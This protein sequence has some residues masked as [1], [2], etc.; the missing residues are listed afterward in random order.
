M[1]IARFYCK[2]AKT[3]FSLLPD[4]LSSRYRGEL[5]A[6]ETVCVAAER[7]KDVMSIANEHRAQN[8]EP[9]TTQ[10]AA[11]RWVLRRCVL[12]AIGMHA[13]RG[14]AVDLVQGLRTASELRERMSTEHAL[15]SLRAIVALNLAS[16]PPPLGFGPWPNADRRRR[17]R[18]Q[19]SMAPEQKAHSP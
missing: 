6:F 9:V 12:F 14:G 11:R 7:S 2:R 1:P 8:E 5:N 17:E 16:L 3:T 15:L 13:L 18:V 19:H 4:F 10:G